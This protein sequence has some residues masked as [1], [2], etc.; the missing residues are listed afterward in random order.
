MAA[1]QSLILGKPWLGRSKVLPSFMALF[2]PNIQ[3]S[4]RLSANQISTVLQLSL[5]KT[6]TYYY[7][8]AGRLKNNLFIDCNDMGVQFIEAGYQT[9]STNRTF[10]WKISSFQPHL[11]IYLP[12]LELQSLFPPVDDPTMLK[13][14]AVPKRETCLT[15]RF[16]FHASKI[17]Q[18]KAM[19]TSSG[20]DNPTQVEVVTA[21]ILKR[22]MS[23]SR[24]NSGSFGPSMFRNAANLRQI[25]IPPLPQNSVGNFI[26]VYP[27]VVENEDDVR[28][29]EL[30]SKLRNG[31]RKIQNEY[32]ENMC[33]LP[34]YDV[35]F[36]WGR[37][38]L[39]RY[40]TKLG[41]RNSFILMDLRNGKG[42]DGIQAVVT[43]EKPQMC[44]FEA[45]DELLTYASLNGE[46]EWLYPR[47]F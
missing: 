8:F 19:A 1:C 12:S 33:R 35:D 34:F 18:L 5:S 17:A 47:G 11:V 30:V 4:D 25:T 26:T 32:K 21:L 6:L 23:A 16:L 10:I 37:P 43:L 38:S 3:G 42:V 36:G 9:L 20:V 13:L 40:A 39:V 27:V 41:Q 44:L 15:R 14:Y 28:F 31:R 22:A 46:N 7:P 45:N 29:P 24:A 2:Y